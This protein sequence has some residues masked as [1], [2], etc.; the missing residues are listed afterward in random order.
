M[1]YED[2]NME[3][4][5]DERRALREKIAETERC[6]DKYFEHAGYSEEIAADFDRKADQYHQDWKEV[7]EEMKRRELGA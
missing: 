2:W 6:A 3:E 7:N 1:S 4:L 5:K